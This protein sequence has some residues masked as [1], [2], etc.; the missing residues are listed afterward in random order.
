MPLVIDVVGVEIAQ[1]GHVLGNYEMDAQV[2]WD[3]PFWQVVNFLYCTPISQPLTFRIF[4]GPL[5]E[6]GVQ[7]GRS[8]TF[9][10]KAVASDW[11]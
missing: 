11:W 4:E 1:H 6:M 3:I 8:A 9:C 2:D 10:H 7:D 5:C